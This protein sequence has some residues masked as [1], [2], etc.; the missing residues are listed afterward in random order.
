MN[1]ESSSCCNHLLLLAYTLNSRPTHDQPVHSYNNLP[2]N[3]VEDSTGNDIP[4]ERPRQHTLHGAP[5]CTP[6]PGMGSA[7]SMMLAPSG[8]HW[9]PLG[10]SVPRLAGVPGNTTHQA[11]PVSGTI[12]AGSANASR[13]GDE[14]EGSDGDLYEEVRSWIFAIPTCSII[15]AGET[16]FEHTAYTLHP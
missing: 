14:D 9:H 12:E 16:S 8:P 5:L 15:F 7:V 4:V 1:P 11:M 6:H 10:V 13:V 3:A 2:S